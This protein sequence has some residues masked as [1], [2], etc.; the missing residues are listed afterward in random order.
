MLF[1]NL[2]HFYHILC[3]LADFDFAGHHFYWWKTWFSVYRANQLIVSVN[4]FIHIPTLSCMFFK[5]YTCIIDILDFCDP[6][7]ISC[8]R[9][10]NNLN[11]I[12]NI[13]TSKI[14]QGL[15]SVHVIERPSWVKHKTL[16]SFEL[17][18]M[19]VYTRPLLR[20]DAILGFLYPSWLW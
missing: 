17:T 20:S 4:K 19:L 16:L 13:T 11:M 12:E 10:F 2:H 5:W 8:D 1:Q 6:L 15:R 14:I 3:Y 7:S 18:S 9:L